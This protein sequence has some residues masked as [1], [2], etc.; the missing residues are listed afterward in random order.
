MQDDA[1]RD[2][3]GGPSICTIIARNY[4]AHA[5][6][7]AE[8]FRA[9]H[10]SG[11]CTVLVIDD[12]TGFIDAAEEPFEVL[13]IEQ[14]GLPD[15]ERMAASY[16]VMELSTAVKPWLLQTLLARPEV[17]SVAYL[18]PDIRVFAPLDEIFERVARHDV[19]L[20]P[21]FTKPLPRDGLKP[22]EE[23]ILIAGSYNLGFIAL[24][25]GETATQLLDWWAERLEAHCLNEPERGRF[26]DQRW[27][28]L[29]PGLWPGI[30]VLRDT[31]FNIAYWNLATRKLEEAGDGYRV[32][33]QPLHFFHF[34]GFD[35]RQP[36][37]LSK[38]QTRVDVAA[39]PAL[40][41]ICGEYAT[42]LL[43]Q[44]FEEANGWPYGWAEMPNGVKL[45]RAARRV[46]RDAAE[47][48]AIADSVFT[49][50]GAAR[51]TEFLQEA[52]VGKREIAGVNRYAKALWDTRA[53]FRNAFSSIEHDNGP[54][55]VGW[56]QATAGDTGIA[57]D[58]LPE[59]SS[60]GAAAPPPKPARTKPGI[61][62]VGYLSSER[63][64]GEAARQILAALRG[65]EAPVA[66]IDAPTEPDRIDPVLA[67]LRE[68]DH[69]YDFNL[70]CVNADMLPLV[71]RGLGKGF[72]E[73]RN[74][75]GLWFWEVSHFPEQWHQA[76]DYVD[77]V[78]VATEHVAETLRPLS[79]TPVHTVRMPI[80]PGE[81]AEASRSELGMPE[82]FC[83][84][85]VFDYR[86]VFRRK[87]PLGLVETFCRAFEPGAGPSL[88]IKSICGDEF[89]A[90]R[91]ALA[92]AVRDRPEIHLLEETVPREM[93]DAMIASCDCYVSLH[94]S[95]GLGLTMAEA[96]YFGKPVIATAYS[97]NLDF[98]TERNSFLVPHTMVE[99]GPDADPYP[100]GKEWADP[101]LDRAAALLRE[102]FERPEEA[103]TRGRRAAEDIRRNHSPEAAAAA[104]Q[105][106]IE[107][108]RRGRLLARLEPPSAA[109][110]KVGAPAGR[111][112]LEHLLDFSEPPARRGAGKVQA[113][114]KRLYM[115]LLRPYVAHQQR[116]NA[117][118]AESLDEL[119]D[120]LR[121]ALRMEAQTEH[122]LYKRI[123][124]ADELV[125]A[126][127]AEPYM[128]D[129]RLA[130]RSHPVLGETIG[131]R[132]APGEA[133]GE[134]YRGFE[135]LF[136][137]SERMI[138]ERQQVYLDLLADREPVLDAGCGRGE[139][140]D[141]LVERG[142]AFQGVDADPDMVERCR[143]KGHAGVE[144]AD[145][146][147]YLEGVAPASLGAIFSAQ[148][149]EHLGF[150]RLKRFLELSRSRLRPGGLLIAETVNPHS[151]AALKAFWV[152]PTHAH[153]L[154]PET[155]LAL[156]A[157]A[158]FAGGD[159]FAPVGSGDW[160]RDRT[161]VGEY[162]VVATAPER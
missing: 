61:N 137:G 110:A 24:R 2:A 136:R 96:M 99:I 122:D 126:A 92:A 43:A 148:V 150:D 89:P 46:Y 93:K 156:C 82:G 71:A 48:G 81:P 100:P 143:E 79:P 121:E 6:V 115:R 47:I 88:A 117:S 161:R 70:I 135:D 152:D 69:P 4:V 11:T 141:L 131:F 21:H 86:S 5:R 119:R 20:T 28:D 40:T 118:V 63:G 107:H 22:S 10:P 30:D 52:E 26:V 124:R 58:L 78:W 64:V 9:A 3:A 15:P 130:R 65:R 158:G 77:E 153:P 147:D 144:Q 83:F 38:H 19:V 105:A 140:L 111:D 80:L 114:A 72:F 33:G 50:P 8:S 66:T 56:L 123:E 32:D 62:V 160:Q 76:F 27:I 29:A 53:D 154:F 73:G 31:S 120:G 45:D 157:L 23:D 142:I 139:L 94:R 41:R 95:E 14:I 87:N 68:E 1:T 149:I 146:I 42:E 91:A 104:I 16:D 109:R 39:N 57:A 75:A 132:T 128:A 133:E 18:D 7:L 59:Q 12:P 103:A 97:G 55:F 102:V 34:S 98:M 51:F 67:E 74:S 84:L 162:A 113:Q 151:A 125:A 25:D 112:L 145:L 17:D 49:E 35:P 101:D 13:T 116:I 155:M 90:E 36:T 134:G 127:A 159:V 37:V 108:G 44:G 129:D 54:A 85:F 106:R 60:N 138:R